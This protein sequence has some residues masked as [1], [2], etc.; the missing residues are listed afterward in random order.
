MPSSI[1]DNTTCMLPQNQ[2]MLVF[3]TGRP[4]HSYVLEE[5]AGHPEIDMATS[6]SSAF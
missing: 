1:S 5:A 4:M 3:K 6:G 2:S